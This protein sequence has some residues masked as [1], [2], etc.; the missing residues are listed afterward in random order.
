MSKL[1]TKKQILDWISDNP[2]KSNNR[3]ISMKNRC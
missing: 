2:K 1:P 3:E